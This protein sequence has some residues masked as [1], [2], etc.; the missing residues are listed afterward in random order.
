MPPRIAILLC[1]VFIFAL[2]IIDVRREKKIS[3]ALWIPLLW[4]MILG[5]RPLS[6]WF[7]HGAVITDNMDSYVMGNPLNEAVFVLLIVFA[8]IVLAGRS[9]TL[10]LL[11]SNAWI[12]LLFLYSGFSILWSDFPDV[13]FRRWVKEVGLLIMVLVVLTEADPVA[14]V[15]A[16][17]RRC[18][19]VLV[20]LSVTLIKYYPDLGR[21]HG[22]WTGATEYLGVTTSKNML[23][24]LCLVSGFY[25]SW[26]ILRRLG[27]RGGSLDRKEAAITIVMLVMISWLLAKANSATSLL[28]F[29]IGVFVLVGLSMTREKLRHVGLYIIATLLLFIVL[30]W[31]F[32]LVEMTVNTMGRDMTFTG[33]SM[34]W[35]DVLNMGTDPLF[36]TGYDSFWLGERL[37]RLWEKHWWQPNQAHNGYIEVYLNLGLIG[38]VL[39]GGVLVSAY[40]KIRRTLLV[41]FQY[42]SLRMAFLA[43]ILFHNLTEASFKGESVMWFILLLVSMDSPNLMKRPNPGDLQLRAKRFTV[44]EKHSPRLAGQPSNCR[45]LSNSTSH[46]V[47]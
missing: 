11:R 16:V 34:L 31:S 15:K 43:M 36:G 45:F 17:L 24:I 33:R 23:G 30:Q 21:T 29:L 19:Y 20:P 39:L 9:K 37:I 47:S 38:L 5:S 28:A 3:H 4:L 6:L 42:G 25:F 8:V 46:T 2:F 10:Q 41:D 22:P 18:A 44:A 26:N 35:K 1:A 7:S 13:S 40:G 12:I 32:G 14:A 27:R